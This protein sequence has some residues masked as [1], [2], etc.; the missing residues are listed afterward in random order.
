MFSFLIPPF[1]EEQW[2]P[3][4]TSIGLIVSPFALALTQ[5]PSSVFEG[6]VGP[7]PVFLLVCIPAIALLIFHGYFVIRERKPQFFFL[8]TLSSFLVTIAWLT[9]VCAVLIN[10]L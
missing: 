5:D 6:K 9:L 7:I 8:F 1:N 4:K 3:V 10:L 2:S